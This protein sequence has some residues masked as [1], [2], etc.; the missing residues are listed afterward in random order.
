MKEKIFLLTLGIILVSSLN[1][2]SANWQNSPGI[3][4]IIKTSLGT[5]VCQL[6]PEKAPQTVENF[7]GLTNGTREWINPKTGEKVKKR[8]YDGLTFHRVI[9]NF[10]IQGGCP[11]GTGTGGPGY[12]FADEISDLKFDIP[13][14]L[15]MANAGPNTNGSQFFIT[16]VPT[17]WLDGR[18]TIFGQVVEGMDIV[19]KIARVPRDN[20]D[21]P[22]QPVIIEKITIQ[23]IGQGKKSAGG[24]TMGKKVVFIVAPQNF[25]DEE[26]LQPKTI[27]EDAGIKVITAS[28]KTGELT[29]MLG[30]KIKADI[31]VEEIKTPEISA[32]VLVGGSGAD[33]YW[34]H[35]GVHQ[36]IK[37]ML[38]QNKPIGAICIAPV[39]LARA[40]VLTGKNATCFSSVKDELV[41]A[42]ANF[43][44][45][46]VVQD[47]LIITA[48]GPTAATEFGQTLLKVLK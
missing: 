23:E 19:K 41:K 16:E 27:L 8:F 26:Y 40:G 3:Y 46:S 10:M 39:T 43:Q 11:L 32:L 36:L 25:R 17:P 6:F 13:G 15:A 22:L 24:E 48:N 47:G 5:I 2:V 33:I 31:L 7:V 1:I 38:V 4:A 34:S 44:S 29:G 18:H 42:G 28:L 45:K 30:A 9:P 12:R 35:L 21:K 37:Q 14:R 20:R